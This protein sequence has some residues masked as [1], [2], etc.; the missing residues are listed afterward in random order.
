MP[1]SAIAT[2]QLLVNIAAAYNVF[3]SSLLLALIYK[4]LVLFSKVQRNN[5]ILRTKEKEPTI[6]STPISTQ[7]SF[8]RTSKK[9]KEKLA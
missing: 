8:T 9:R 7:E 2:N 5:C 3:I 4:N 1:A 6:E